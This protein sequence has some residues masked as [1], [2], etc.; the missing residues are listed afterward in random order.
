M[1]STLIVT[2]S[3]LLGA[4]GGGDVEYKPSE[5]APVEVDV[6]GEPVPVG[7][8]PRATYQL[9]RWS[10]MPNGHREA[11]TRRDGSSGT[12]YA[13]R[14]ID[15]SGRRFRYLGE[16]DTREEAEVDDKNPGRMAELVSGSIS[17]EVSD[18]VCAK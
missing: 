2:A 7:S 9:V 15:C 13:R 1:R 8:D 3:L 5:I 10:E 14:E 11:L 18:F 6:E 17:T 4:C 12:S 16:G